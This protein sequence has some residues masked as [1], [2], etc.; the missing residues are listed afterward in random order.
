M[1]LMLYRSACDPPLAVIK[2]NP[3]VLDATNFCHHWGEGERGRGR[4]RERGT[5]RTC[6]TTPMGSGGGDEQRAQV[7]NHVLAVAVQPWRVH[8]PATPGSQVC[9]KRLGVCRGAA[10][11]LIPSGG[12]PHPRPSLPLTLALARHANTLDAEGWRHN[13][14]A[15]QRSQDGGEQEK[16]IGRRAVERRG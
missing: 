5:L 14:R 3:C 6:A 9:H 7:R 8:H 12:R 4:G 11:Q 13:G 1:N 16:E 2:Q 15:K 10:N